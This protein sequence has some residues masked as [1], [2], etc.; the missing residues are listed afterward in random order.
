MINTMTW[1]HVSSFVARVKSSLAVGSLPS[2]V[3]TAICDV[4]ESEYV[5]GTP[6][7]LNL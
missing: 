1:G 6:W 2:L 5:Q 4:G 3:N 7:K